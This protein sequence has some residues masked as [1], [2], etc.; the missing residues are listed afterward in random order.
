MGYAE[1]TFR[2]ACSFF[3]LLLLT[4]LMGKTEISQL[5]VFTFITA[6]TIGNIASS[7]STD[8]RVEIDKGVYSLLGWTFLTI[9]MGYI[10][11]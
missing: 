6:I 10:G 2:I 1:S 3:V 8:E 11:M 5:N 4:R 9:A 7:L